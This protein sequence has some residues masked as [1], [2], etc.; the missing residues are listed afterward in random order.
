MIVNRLKD[1]LLRWTPSDGYRLIRRLYR[2]YQDGWYRLA[3]LRGQTILYYGTNLK[4]P[5][6]HIIAASSKVQPLRNQGVLIAAEQLSK[7]YPNK[8]LVDIGANIGDT[9]A[10]MASVSSNPMILVEPSDMYMQFLRNNV[11]GF[12]NQVTLKNCFVGD[13]ELVYGQLLHRSGTAELEVGLD[14]KHK[15][16]KLSSLAGDN[17]CFVKIDTDGFDCNVITSS[18]SWL[19][20]TK[21][22]VVYE[23]CIRND[24]EFSGAVSV[25]WGLYGI[26]YWCWIVYDDAGRCIIKT[27]EPEVVLDM[28][29]YLLSVW[30]FPGGSICYYDMLCIHRDDMDIYEAIKDKNS[31]SNM[32]FT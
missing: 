7:K 23:C 14:G 18:L 11:S 21:P 27:Q 19:E 30:R 8:Y 10:I 2:K 4:V 20:N 32:V 13:G 9:A 5:H 16:H 29:R 26:G 12:S 3:G 6:G 28:L 17:V 31:V 1:W 15:T 22:S 25:F 24:L